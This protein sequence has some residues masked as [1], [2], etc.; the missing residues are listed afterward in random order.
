MQGALSEATFR[1]AITGLGMDPGEVL[2]P[3]P[4]R[5]VEHQIQIGAM[6]GGIAQPDGNIHGNVAH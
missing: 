6:G 4:P 5:V 1:A 2:P 3:S